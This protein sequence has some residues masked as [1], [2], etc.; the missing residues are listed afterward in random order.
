VTTNQE[1]ALA[2]RAQ[3]IVRGMGA[4]FAR[5]L[6]EAEEQQFRAKLQAIVDSLHEPGRS[7][8]P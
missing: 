5:G 8:A 3:E 1:L 6:T 2:E 4:A 7:T